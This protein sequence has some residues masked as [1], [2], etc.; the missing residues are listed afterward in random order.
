MVVVVV[1]SSMVV[2]GS[3]EVVVVE[4]SMVVV[5]SMEV[6]VVVELSMVVVGSIEVVVVE[7]SSWATVWVMARATAMDDTVVKVFMVMNYLV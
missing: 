1:E 7:L 5:G 4:L 6:V 3:I 2:V